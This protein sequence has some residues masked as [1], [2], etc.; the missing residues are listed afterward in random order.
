MNKLQELKD[1]ILAYY[2]LKEN[3]AD[4]TRYKRN[5]EAVGDVSFVPERDGTVASFNSFGAGI[6]LGEKSFHHSTKQFVVSAWIK[7][8][9]HTFRKNDKVSGGG[10]VMLIGRLGVVKNSHYDK[11]LHH[12]LYF[13]HANNTKDLFSKKA[14]PIGVWTQ[15]A[16][17]LD[18]E[19]LEFTFF[20]DGKID[21]VID[22]SNHSDKMSIGIPITKDSRIGF[23]IVHKGIGEIG[24]ET[25][26]SFSFNGLISDVVVINKAMDPKDIPLLNRKNLSD[27]FLE[28]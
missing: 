8:R 27:L 7:V 20:I 26:S 19:K 15:I 12:T 4:L 2:P 5:G 14:V 17:M 28:D 11:H 18:Q 1:S 10:N 25:K 16:I 13:D 24:I 3:A 22:L 21:S 23:P 6:K 9:E